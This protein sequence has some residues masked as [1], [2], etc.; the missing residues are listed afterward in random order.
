MPSSTSSRKRLLKASV[1]SLYSA[2]G[3]TH[4][5]MEE[6]P[7]PPPSCGAIIAGWPAWCFGL[8]LRG[9]NIKFIIH[10]ASPWL[11][12]LP[13][14][15][16]ATTIIDIKDVESAG[17]I[18]LV[19]HWFSDVEPPRKLGL[20][21]TTAKTITSLRRIRHFPA[22][23]W[24]I[25]QRKIT[26]SSIGGVTDG[27]WTLYHYEN[28]DTNYLHMMNSRSSQDLRSV[29]SSTMEGRPCPPPGSSN[30]TTPTVIQLRPNTFHGSGILPWQNRNCFVVTPSVFSPT[31]WVRRRI[32]D[33]EWASILDLPDMIFNKLPPKERRSIIDDTSLLPLGVV[34]KVL[35]SFTNLDQVFS[36]NP[37]RVCSDLSNATLVTVPKTKESLVSVVASSDRDSRNTKAT[38]NDD[39]EVPVYIWNEA[40]V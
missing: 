16:P 30:L 25:D 9:W 27:D 2:Y 32:S 20:W 14:W 24:K 4:G 38:K 8:H 33:Q 40:I 23:N 19:E 22:S 17:L 6:V 3:I 21:Y 35:D 5:K 29:M 1:P 36:P 13:T 31:S 12:Q 26:H 37:K 11:S 10:K 34:L 28:G 7:G 15:F 39:S 18:N